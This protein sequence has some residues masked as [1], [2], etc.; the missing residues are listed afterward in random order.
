MSACPPQFLKSKPKEPR[1]YEGWSYEGRKCPKHKVKLVKDDHECCDCCC[2]G[3]DP[4]WECPKC[5]E[6]YTKAYNRWF[7][8]WGHI[9]AVA[10]YLEVKNGVILRMPPDL[11]Y[12]QLLHGGKPLKRG[13]WC[14]IGSGGYLKPSTK[15]GVPNMIVVG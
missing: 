15:N 9:V 3:C 10:H 8:K 2:G 1:T 13:Q 6:L 11:R 12:M 14:K 4:T 5:Q 7:H